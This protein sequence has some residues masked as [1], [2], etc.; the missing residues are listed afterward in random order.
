MNL[1]KTWNAIDV[2]VTPKAQSVLSLFLRLYV[3]QVFFASGLTKIRDWDTTLFLFT[4]EYHVPVL[5]PAIAAAAGTTG[6]LLLPVLL[7]LGLFTRFGA[8]GLFVLNAVAVISY[9]GLAE[10]ALAQHFTWGVM[11]ATI[12][13]F[14]AGALSV[15]AQWRRVAA[16]Y[17]IL[18][19]CASAIPTSSARPSGSTRNSP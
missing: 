13:V 8:A 14:G 2:W 6:E 19:N 17:S 11:L 16:R 3:A 4:E 7:V 10:A 18:R 12:A 15:D 9:P 5:P 1:F